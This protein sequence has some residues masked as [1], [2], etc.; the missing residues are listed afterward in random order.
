MN[1]DKIKQIIEKYD[2]N[3]DGVIN[4]DEFCAL[5]VGL[6]HEDMGVNQ[7]MINRDRSIS[8]PISAADHRSTQVRTYNDHV[9]TC[10]LDGVLWP[11]LHSQSCS[12]HTPVARGVCWRSRRFCC[13]GDSRFHQCFG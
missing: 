2:E 10:A 9:H 7:R 4:L 11:V 6:A 8:H 12:V 3:H 1:D 5:M 13:I